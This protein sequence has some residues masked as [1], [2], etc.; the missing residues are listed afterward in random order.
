MSP[1]I[2]VLFC[3]DDYILAGKADIL[4]KQLSQSGAMTTEIIDGATDTIDAT[5]DAIGQFC[6][7][8]RQIDLFASEKLV[9]LKNASFLGSDRTMGSEAIKELLVQLIEF[10]SSDL[11]D[12]IELVITT[13]AFNKKYSFCKQLVA[14][15]KEGKVAF[16][17]IPVG[18]KGKLTTADFKKLLNEYLTGHNLQMG[19]KE[20][21]YFCGMI[22]SSS[23]VFMNELD[24]LFIYTSN[25]PPTIQ[26]IEAIVTMSNLQEPWDLLDAFGE[27]NARKLLRILH[28]LYDLRVDPIFLIGQLEQRTNELLILTDC[29]KRG[30][31]KL[32]AGTSFYGRTET[33]V[34]WSEALTGDDGDALADLGKYKLSGWQAS[35]IADQIKYWDRVTLRLARMKLIEAH[36]QMVSVGT[37]PKDLLELTLLSLMRPSAKV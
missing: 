31:A 7:A 35:R 18:K 3:E 22:S 9:W 13:T 12:G 8:A 11:P 19:A 10:L 4:I 32:S 15:E 25:N 33:N 5:I 24:K 37:N 23:R 21:E 34:T 29:V 27:R 26:D 36:V 30:Y 20:Q 17:E 16:E 2:H 28:N 14:L 1:R 6:N